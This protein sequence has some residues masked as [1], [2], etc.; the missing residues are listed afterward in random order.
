MLYIDRMILTEE[1]RPLS[2]DSWNCTTLRR[3]F[4]LYENKTAHETSRVLP[5]ILNFIKTTRYS[6]YIILFYYF[7]FNILTEQ[8]LEPELVEG[9]HPYM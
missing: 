6:A 5:N 1:A 9:G 4:F 7:M 2:R 3:P 8:A